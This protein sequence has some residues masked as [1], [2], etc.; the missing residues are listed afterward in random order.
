MRQYS[1]SIALP[2]PVDGDHIEIERK[3]GLL[4]IRIPKIKASES[5]SGKPSG[6]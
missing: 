5:A 3:E 1:Q 2:G 4:L 6:K